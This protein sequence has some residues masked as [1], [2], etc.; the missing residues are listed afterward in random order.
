M[1]LLYDH[2]QAEIY[3]SEITLVTTDPLL[4][5]RQLKLWI[6]H[7]HWVSGL[8]PSS[9]ILNTKN[10]T[11]RKVEVFPKRCA[12]QLLRTAD[13]IISPEI[14]LF[15]M[16]LLHFSTTSKLLSVTTKFLDVAMCLLT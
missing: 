1:F 9:R 16:A 15:L 6:N 7:N 13:D 11:F 10:T 3:L 8:F 2:L 14:Q 12:F 5:G 4:L